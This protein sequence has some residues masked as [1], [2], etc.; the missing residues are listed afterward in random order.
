MTA[1]LTI[2]NAPAPIS[3][4]MPLSG[5]HVV[6]ISHTIRVWHSS[7]C[8]RR[9]MRQTRNANVPDASEGNAA[10]E[11][12]GNLNSVS[13]PVFTDS[14]KLEK[15]LLT[16]PAIVKNHYLPRLAIPLSVN[17]EV[18]VKTVRNRLSPVWLKVK[19]DSN[20]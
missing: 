12:P 5:L 2:G 9:Q 14:I 17:T 3:D 1:R 20:S 8:I 16:S 6:A 19:K 13:C 18:T 4:Q 15:I 11:R 10:V 7:E